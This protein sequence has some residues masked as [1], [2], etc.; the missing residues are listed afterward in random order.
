MPYTDSEIA[1]EE[2]TPGFV[3]EDTEDDDTVVEGED[4][5]GA[6]QME[7]SDVIDHAKGVVMSIKKATLDTYTPQGESDWFKRSLKLQL[8]VG[9]AGVDGKGRYKNKHFF[10]RI[11]I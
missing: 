2:E 6:E 3:K 4:V 10:P 5:S 1:A 11:L 8:V 9:P 7:R